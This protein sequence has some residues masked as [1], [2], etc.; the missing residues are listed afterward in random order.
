MPD[1]DF[2]TVVDGLQIKTY[3]DITNLESS[4]LLIFLHGDGCVADYMKT[5]ANTIVRKNSLSIVMARPGC[6]VSNRRSRGYHGNSDYYTPER[7]DAVSKSVH[8]LKTHY[9]ARKAFL[10][11]HSGGVATAGIIAGKYPDL[12]DG[13]VAVAFP[14]NIPKWRAQGAAQKSLG[15]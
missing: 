14:A 1:N 8:S 5:M 7:I 3:G 12:V 15:K 11:G 10:I 6:V 13:F 4:I 9:K 2:T